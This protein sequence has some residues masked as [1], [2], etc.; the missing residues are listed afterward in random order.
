M[1]HEGDATLSLTCP[2]YTGLTNYTTVPTPTL[3]PALDKV[4]EWFDEPAYAHLTTDFCNDYFNPNTPDD[5]NVS[6][7]SY[8]AAAQLPAWSSLLGLPWKLVYDKEGDNDGMVSID[9]AK[10]GTYVKTIQADHWD[11]SGKR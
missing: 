5:P 6:Y 3:K 8:G 2:K 4:I 11:L 7:Y 10:W 1:R 9:S